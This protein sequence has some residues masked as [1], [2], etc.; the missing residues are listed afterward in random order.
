[1]LTGLLKRNV[2]SSYFTNDFEFGIGRILREGHD[3]GKGLRAYHGFRSDPRNKDSFTIRQFEFVRVK[4][5][6]NG[7][8]KAVDTNRIAGQMG[9][10]ALTTPITYALTTF[11]RVFEAVYIIGK[12]FFDTYATVYKESRGEANLSRSF[13]TCLNANLKALAENLNNLWD[14][15]KNDF[16]CAFVMELA[17]INGAL[18]DKNA[19][20]MQFLFTDYEKKWN[21]VRD[22][23]GVRTLDINET[24][25][26]GSM[27]FFSK[28]YKAS[29]PLIWL[30][31]VNEC[32][33]CA[34]QARE[35]LRTHPKYPQEFGDPLDWLEGVIDSS[36]EQ[37]VSKR[38][39]DILGAVIE[40][41]HE[42]TA[43]DLKDLAN[44][45]HLKIKFL[46]RYFSEISKTNHIGFVQYG[47]AAPFSKAKQDRIEVIPVTIASSM[48][49][50]RINL[51]RES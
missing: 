26:V 10:L 7:W 48:N 38:D 51:K 45:K 21:R 40:E 39:I 41:S 30:F 16:H 31:M 18:D 4:G 50:S 11:K 43:M 20:R 17:A 42:F 37:R 13:V 25:G 15:F 8:R 6:S 28:I 35:I 12:V 49:E 36:F 1:M 46:M 19:L 47:C 3:K 24:S 5:K 33:K 29:T 23:Q 44:S 22:E 14:D 2:D 9:I 34:D 32:E 27:L